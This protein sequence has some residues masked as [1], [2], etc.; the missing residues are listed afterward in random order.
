LRSPRALEVPT[1]AELGVTDF[2]VDWLFGVLV[3]TDSPT[4]II[5]RHNSVFD[6]I[7][8]QASVRDALE[9]QGLAIGGA[10]IFGSH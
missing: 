9:R 3:L 10:T 1:L 2:K 4:T 6:E 8:D 5:D 7:L